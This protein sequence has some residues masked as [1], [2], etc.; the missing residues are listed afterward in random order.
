MEA[1]LRFVAD[2]VLLTGFG[3]D[4]PA[5]VPTT[6][7]FEAGTTPR[8]PGRPLVG[9]VFYRAHL[10]SGNTTF[11]E[12]L[13]AALDEAGADVRS[14]FCYSL[15]PDADGP[16]PALELCR[17]VDVLITTVLAMGGAAAG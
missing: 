2:A 15:R 17:G 3:F 14:V 5:E 9:V 8:R 1:C 10:I 6:G 7:V 4:P 12:D 11:V 16:V 13:A